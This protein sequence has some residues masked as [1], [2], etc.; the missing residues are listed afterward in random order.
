MNI[1]EWLPEMAMVDGVWE[2][3]CAGLYA[4]FQKDIVKGGRVYKNR[5]VWWDRRVVDGEYE[6]G[7]WHLISV[8]DNELQERLFDPRRAEKLPWCGPTISNSDD[9]FVR[10][11]D[12]QEGR[13]KIRTYLW[14]EP[15]DY[16]IIMEKQKKGGR[17]IAFL[18]TAYHIDG[19]S[20]RRRLMRKYQNRVP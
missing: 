20:T 14:L 11:W 3:V 18:I 12:Y 4:I 2:E 10:A 1:P 7:F 19:D 6:E 5:P 13:K 15:L 9:G 17:D 8:D 16:V